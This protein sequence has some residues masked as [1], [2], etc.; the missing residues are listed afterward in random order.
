[1]LCPPHIIACALQA[2]VNFCTSTR[3][4]ANFCPKTGHH[5]RFSMKQQDRSSERDQAA[6]DFATKTVFYFFWSSPPNLRAKSIPKEDNIGF[7]AKYSP[8]CCL[9]SNASGF[10]CAS[11]PQKFLCLPKHTTLA[12][13]R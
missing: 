5:K 7:E 12:P 2:R 4:P 11:V 6:K 3:G 10:G 13:D 9:I 8:D 1:M